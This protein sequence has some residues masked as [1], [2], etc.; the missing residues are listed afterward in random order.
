MSLKTLQDVKE[1]GGYKVYRTGDIFE[2]VTWVGG[3]ASSAEIDEYINDHP[4]FIDDKENTISFKLQEGPIKE[5]GVN[6]CQVDTLIRAA[7]HIIEGLDKQIPCGENIIAM[8]ALN[9]ALGALILRETNR[10]SRGVE[11]TSQA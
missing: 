9:T 10:A 3:S 7:Y 1:I 2:Y 4:I 5:H 8:M 11:G 6:G